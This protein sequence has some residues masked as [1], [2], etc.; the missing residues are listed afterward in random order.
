MPTIKVHGAGT[1][2]CVH[3]NFLQI[4]SVDL[5][6]VSLCWSSIDCYEFA[7]AVGHSSD[8]KSL[9]DRIGNAWNELGVYYMQVASTLDFKKEPKNVEKLWKNS[10]SCIMDGL[11]RFQ[12]TGNLVNQSLLYA[13][14]GKLMYSCA[15]SH[16]IRL[17]PKEIGTE[18]GSTDSCTSKKDTSAATGELVQKEKRV[19]EYSHQEKLYYSKSVEHY[20]NAKQ[21]LTN[22][23]CKFELSIL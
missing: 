8:Q 14:L 6:V 15:Q 9:E 2:E 13:N 11:A 21:V 3:K 17:T 18:D 22:N 20:L 4:Y 23:D 16:G 1:Y 12:S 10:Y 7:R 19:S 5:F